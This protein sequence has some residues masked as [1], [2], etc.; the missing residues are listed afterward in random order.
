MLSS[1]VLLSIGALLRDAQ[2]QFVPAPTDLTSAMGYAGVPVRY[3]KVPTG[4]CELDP[5]VQSFS[6]YADVAEDQHIFFWFFEAR[7]Q[8][9]TTA[10]L[11]VW[12]NGGPGSSSMIGL[13][14][15]LGP[16]GID[17][18]GNVYNNPY[19]WSNASNM[20]FIDQPTMVGFSYSKPIPGYVDANSGSIVQLPDASECPDYVNGTCGTFSYPDVTLT[21]NST[22]SAAPNF[23]KTLQGFMG[24]FPQY[25]RNGFHFTSESYGG[26]YGPVFN[27][28]IEEM[29]AKNIPGAVNISLESVMIGNGWYDPIIQYQAYYN[30]TVFPGNTYDYRGF[31]PAQEKQM[32]NNLYGPGNCLDQLNACKASGSNAVCSSADNFCANQ[33]EN[34]YDLYLGRDEYDMRELTPDPFPYSFYDDYLN[35]PEVQAAIGAFVNFS[36]YNNAVGTNFGYTGDDGREVGTIED[37][38][39]LVNDGIT[40]ALYAGD[41]DYNCNWLGGQAVANEVA[42]KGWEGAGYV[43]MSTSDGVAHG[44]VKQAGKFSFTRI[45]ESGHEVPFYQPLASLEMFERVIHG[46]DVATGT[47]KVNSSYYHTKGEKESTY[48]EGNATVQWTVVPDNTTYDRTTNRPGPPWGAEKKTRLSMRKWR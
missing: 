34:L 13:F 9:P 3:K 33:I 38:R 47:V 42:V 39:S 27:A 14:Q 35:S 8:D 12:I 44:Q 19:S 6:G 15:E 29:N 22:A 20:L 40:V 21:A 32:Y 45:Y 37:L 26:H 24:A 16:C 41:A 17:Y 10:P 28:Y 5:N 18:F 23:W 46:L 1:L 25:A 43:N 30:F 31:T 48:R 36:D 11:T 2:A 4:I 7:N